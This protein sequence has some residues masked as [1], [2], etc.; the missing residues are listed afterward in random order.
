MQT[1]K[2]FYIITA[3]SLALSVL[4]NPEYYYA[5]SVINFLKP[6]SSMNQT[7]GNRTTLVTEFY[8]Y[9]V[10]E[11]NEFGT[12]PTF[13]ALALVTSIF[14]DLFLVIVIIGLNI[15][16]LIEIKKTTKRR[17]EMANEFDIQEI[18]NV[19]G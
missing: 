3:C 12:S 5:F 17:M 1:N 14:R 13:Y 11:F 6:V 8:T 10:Y 4:V 18:A 7:V 16:I 9:N 2:A 19:T 15:L